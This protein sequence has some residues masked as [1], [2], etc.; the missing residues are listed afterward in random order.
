MN[1]FVFITIL[2]AI[3][4]ACLSFYNLQFLIIFGLTF[5]VY[6][7]MCLDAMRRMNNIIKQMPL[8]ERN[9]K[10]VFKLIGFFFFMG[11]VTAGYV[12]AMF[13]INKFMY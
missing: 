4:C 6:T 5:T 11:I 10:M 3:V 8:L 1:T 2:S 12:I 7:P 9:E 13:G